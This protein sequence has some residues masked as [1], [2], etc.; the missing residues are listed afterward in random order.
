MSHNFTVQPGRGTCN[1]QRSKS[2]LPIVSGH[3]KRYLVEIF[4][5][6]LLT[7]SQSVAGYP[8]VAGIVRNEVATINRAPGNPSTA[9]L[10]KPGCITVIDYH[11]NRSH[12]EFS[13]TYNATQAAR[14]EVPA[15]WR[16]RYEI[17][18]TRKDDDRVVFDHHGGRHLFRSNHDGTYSPTDSTSGTLLLQGKQHIWIDKRAIQ[19]GFHGSFLTTLRFPDNQTLTL[20]YQSGQLDSVTDEKS[21]KINFVHE[22]GYLSKV[23][24]PDGRARRYTSDPCNTLPR[25]NTEPVPDDST[26][27]GSE[28]Q[29]PP[30]EAPPERCDTQEN[31]VPGFNAINTRP[32][33]STLDTR[34]ASCQSYFVEFYGTV[35]GAQIETGLEDH[36]P[37]SVMVPTSRSFPVIDFINGNELVVV[38]SRDVASPSYN[39]PDEPDALFDRLM[40]DGQQIQT[41]ALDRLESEG[42]LSGT[43]NG[44]STL[45]TYSE[46]QSVTLHVLIRQDMA[47]A[48]HWQQIENARAALAAR[49]G[50]R[51]QVVIIP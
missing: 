38:R 34:P 35:R 47:S 43:E 17:R 40:R 24:L 44:R 50:I 6:A 5:C 26:T 10:C 12:L 31:P 7:A 33:V 22:N 42:V 21:V 25:P 4:A 8:D 37:Y 27:T 49:Y 16:H 9:T 32:G 18:L 1:V 45:I 28:E 14:A 19:H 51:L 46:L 48:A 13:R 11:S 39:N 23:Q 36:P 20:H 41:R 2:P 15:R 30:T 29:E 3:L